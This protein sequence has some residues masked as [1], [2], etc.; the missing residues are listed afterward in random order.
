MPDASSFR[1]D[2][3]HHRGDREEVS[4]VHAIRRETNCNDDVL[5]TSVP[6]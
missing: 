5:P 3:L 2:L 1:A 6:A 4:K